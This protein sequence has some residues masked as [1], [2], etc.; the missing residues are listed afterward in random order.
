M[1]RYQLNTNLAFPPDLISMAPGKPG[2]VVELDDERCK[3][4]GRFLRLRVA[5]G[6]LTELEVEE[7]PAP[8]EPDPPP[9]PTPPPAAAIAPRPA[10]PAAM[11]TSPTPESATPKE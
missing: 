10:A 4:F 1:K 8:P 6:D 9:A 2:D 3:V 11:P 7:P 5:V